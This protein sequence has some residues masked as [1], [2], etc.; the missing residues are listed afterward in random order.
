LVFSD[1]NG[2]VRTSLVVGLT[3]AV[4]VGIVVTVLVVS[5][6][7]RI[8]VERVPV[9]LVH[10][11]GGEPKSMRWI[12]S[13]LEAQGRSVMTVALPHQGSDDIAISAQVVAAA[14][15]ASDADKIDFVGYS[16]GGLA[17]RSYIRHLG[18]REHARRVVLLGTPNHGAPV[19][20]LAIAADPDSCTGA[21]S[22]LPPGS[23]FLRVLNSEDETPD[24][25]HYVSIWSSKDNVVSPPET[26]S[27]EGAVNIRLQDVC[28]D[29]DVT[30]EQLLR[31]PLPM[32]LVM[33]ALGPGLDARP[34]RSECEVLRAEGERALATPTPAV[35]AGV[36]DVRRRLVS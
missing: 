11:Y 33:R 4:V 19:A 29:S 18:G 34:P 28:S 20:L 10:G 2:G 26:A 6:P 27:L 25:P 16:V 35:S 3:V 22:Q 32:G 21:C 1:E 24:G 7:D 23:A 31:L 13:A 9:I 5:K 17:V 30:H 12:E 36:R 8:A 14:A 15:V